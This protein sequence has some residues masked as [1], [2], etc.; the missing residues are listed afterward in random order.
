MPWYQDLPWKGSADFGAT[1]KTFQ[2]SRQEAAQ[3]LPVT[4]IMEAYT[5]L[6]VMAKALNELAS[7]TPDWRTRITNLTTLATFRE[8]LAKQLR[9]P[10]AGAWESLMGPITFDTEGQNTLLD[11]P[12]VQVITGKLMTVFP[13]KYKVHDVVYNL[14]W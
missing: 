6:K 9:A 4:R 12:L 13:D 3:V 11:P 14:G 8:S 2:Q 1:L 10:Q 5:T 7:A